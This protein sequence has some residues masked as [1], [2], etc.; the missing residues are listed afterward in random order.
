MVSGLNLPERYKVISELGSGACGTVYRACD[1]VLKRDV[2]VKIVHKRKQCFDDHQI[3]RFHREAKACGNL[4]H[5]SL[6][7]VY[8]F[9]V[10]E[11]REPYLVME[12]I[13]GF[14]LASEIKKQGSLEPSR[15]IELGVEIAQAMDYAHRHG[16]V[17]RDLKSSNLLVFEDEKGS[18]RVKVIDFGLVKV[19]ELAEQE[20]RLT[21]SNSI[22]GSPL[23]M[24]PEQMEGVGVGERSDIYSL[25]TILFE[26]LTGRPPFEADLFLELVMLKNQ[27]NGPS[28]S[29]QTDSQDIPGIL[30]EIVEK[31]LRL[32]PQERF[33]SME[34][35]AKELIR[36]Q[37]AIVEEDLQEDTEYGIEDQSSKHKFSSYIELF[38]ICAGLLII[39]C[40]A[41]SIV[42]PF[43]MHVGSEPHQESTRPSGTTQSL[44]VSYPVM[45]GESLKIDRYG[46]PS[47]DAGAGVLDIKHI[48]NGWYKVKA[49]DSVPI[50]EWKKLEGLK[51]CRMHIVGS[52]F[53]SNN[54]PYI[55]QLPLERLELV[56]TPVDDKSLKE[57]AKISTLK[58]IVFRGMNVTDNDLVLLKDLGLKEIHLN[59]CRRVTGDSMKIVLRQWPDLE[60]LYISGSPIKG[61]DFSVI[62]EF[63][64]L[65]RVNAVVR[66]EKEFDYIARSKSIDYLRMSRTNITRGM[67]DK[68][69]TMKQLKVIRLEYCTH[70]NEYQLTKLK[71]SLP[72]CHFEI[73]LSPNVGSMPIV[74]I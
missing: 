27:N 41:L 20:D 50:E 72:G 32:N 17:H 42:H 11:N 67:L 16:V 59:H 44:P 15:V 29:S 46:L 3:M 6:V 48:I 33:S 13:E 70:L 8:D 53:N 62:P 36:A 68:L 26:A 23:Y 64:K 14:T 2:A 57:L 47:I 35:L 40:L 56:D 37:E 12:L 38:S 51:V 65:K 74:K 39:S 54:L 34:E 31:C 22:V 1:L 58:E 4:K 18:K 5:D 7:T 28:P 24:S 19:D 52:E 9:G 63:K 55:R 21:K 66:S 73:K 43:K 60:R 30:D 69:A 10:N 71:H 49:I 61:D 25:G 45:K